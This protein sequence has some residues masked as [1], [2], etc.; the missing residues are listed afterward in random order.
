[1][2]RLAPALRLFS[3]YVVL[4][5]KLPARRCCEPAAATSGAQAAGERVRLAALFRNHAVR[6]NYLGARSL[7]TTP[8][9][10]WRQGPMM[11]KL[12]RMVH[13][14]IAQSKEA[15]RDDRKLHEN[16]LKH[17]AAWRHDTLRPS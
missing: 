15:L 9:V 3:N 8:S 17:A 16:L 14:F 4:H 10:N 7:S 1:M 2:V 11:R 5:T 13:D 6:F 12:E